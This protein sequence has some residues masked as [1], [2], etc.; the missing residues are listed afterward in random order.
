MSAFK[1]QVLGEMDVQR[2]LGENGHAALT[3]QGLG[4]KLLALFDRF[5]QGISE[6]DLRDFLIQILKE[7]RENEDAEQVVNVFV[8]AFNT[9]WCRGGKGAKQCFHKA[10]K[11]LFEEFPAA[12]M[13]LLP[14]VP[15]FGYWKDLLLLVEEIK[16]TP[17]LGI[18]YSALLQAVWTV[19]GTQLM[20]DYALLEAHK[21]SGAG[22][23]PSLS[24][25]G[26]WAPR[27]GNHF[28]KQLNAVSNISKVMFGNDDVISEDDVM[29]DVEGGEVTMGD[30]SHC[31]QA[32]LAGKPRKVKYRLVVS[33]LN[34]SLDVPEVK[35]A[36]GNYAAINISSVPSKCMTKFVK[37]FANEDLR[38]LP[39]GKEEETGNRFPEKQDRV[40]CRQ[41]LID[42]VVNGKGVKGS[43]NYPHEYVEKA[44]ST[45]L[46]TTT[47]LALNAQWKSMRESIEAMVAER[48]TS[49]QKSD[50][51]MEVSGSTGPSKFS[52]GKIVPLSDVS[53]SMSGTPMMVSIGLGILCSEL[54]NEA[55][56]DLVLTFTD[57]AKWE[58]LGSCVSFTDKVTK[59]QRAP[60]GGST[61][62]YAAMNRVAD[63]VRKSK[64]KQDDIPNLLVISDM[65]FNQAN[66][67]GG[68][69]YYYS[70][71]RAATPWSTSFEEIK[72]LFHDLGLEVHGEPLEPPTIIFWNVRGSVGYPAASDDEGVILLSGYSPALMK[73]LLSGEM[74]EEVLE[75]E[76]DSESGDVVVKKRKHQITP[77]EAMRKVLY[78]DALNPVRDV[79]KTL[80]PSDLR[81]RDG[82]ILTGAVHEEPVQQPLL[83]GGRGGR[84]RG[85]GGRGGRGRR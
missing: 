39:T 61:N 10:L 26:K 78:E 55:F 24:F 17:A 64:L 60:W 77:T 18:D 44:T 20:K 49:L 29:V 6:K 37:A 47:K 25:A 54:T 83:H 5:F 15:E 69:N 38:N 30:V 33:A 36:G 53:G 4:D 75:E 80:S 82:D 12:V 57:D 71:T 76:V 85:R 16:T 79:L 40:Q 59:L 46:S 48:V 63:V 58:D 34:A 9:R 35:M 22:G 43:Q 62:F 27:E 84:G 56:R 65:Q 45:Q 51:K 2:E 81:V 50:D 74:E 14:L 70:S 7:A 19:Y 52:L 8:M 68:F 73:F 67:A 3:A 41:H 42:S 32:S 23:K 66:G 28:D 13:K 72:K 21:A 31:E 1:K 11:I